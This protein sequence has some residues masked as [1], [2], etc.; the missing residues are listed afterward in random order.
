MPVLRVCAY[1]GID[2]VAVSADDTVCLI[3]LDIL[4]EE[5]RERNAGI[6]LDNCEDCLS[7]FDCRDCYKQ[8]I[9]RGISQSDSPKIP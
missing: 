8:T 9:R 2:F 7:V 6:I 3:C 4:K 5:A 1:C